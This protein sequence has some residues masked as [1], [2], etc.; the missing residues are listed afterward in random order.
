M[1]GGIEDPNAHSVATA[2]RAL[3]AELDGS[4]RTPIG[5]HARVE[6]DGTLHLT[7]LVARADGTF[8]LRREISGGRADAERL[9]HELGASL[10]TDSPRDIFV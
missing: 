9:G 3:L 5:G 7:G 2:E 4:C 6:A 8:Q 10:R 1:L